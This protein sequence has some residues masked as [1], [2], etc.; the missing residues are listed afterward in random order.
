M[1]HFIPP[2][3][4]AAIPVSYLQPYATISNPETVGACSNPIVI[5]LPEIEILVTSGEPRTVFV[6]FGSEI[7]SSVV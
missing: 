4:P 5:V 1:K 7:V 6:V 2:I 3:P